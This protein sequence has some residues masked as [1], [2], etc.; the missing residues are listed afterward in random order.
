[1]LLAALALS[2]VATDA[3]TL[4][5][6][7][8]V[9][10]IAGG[11]VIRLALALLGDRIEMARRQVAISRFLVAVII[12]QLAGSSLAGILADLVGRRGVFAVSTAMMGGA[13]AATLVGFR[14]A[15]RAL[16]DL[17]TAIG[18][19]RHPRERP[20]PDAFSPGLRRAVAIFGLFLRGAALEERGAGGPT[21]AGLAPAGFA[22]GGL[23]YS[24]LIGWLMRTLGLRRMLMAAGLAAAVANLAI[25]F[26][27]WQ[28]DAAALCCSASG[29]ICCTVY[30]R[31]RS[32]SS[33]RRV[34]PPRSRSTPFR[35]SSGRR[36]A[37]C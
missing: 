25:G 24:V 16:L 20:C 37:W 27:G 26:G 1:M 18:R 12:G 19:Y 10:G 23:V 11:G 13:L 21:Q 32:P 29:S 3:A 8:V 33:P 14:H 34:A 7:R 36:S 6:L 9:A 2:T 17:G 4:F 15:S 30:S 28:F 5:V 35:S 31:R 22:I